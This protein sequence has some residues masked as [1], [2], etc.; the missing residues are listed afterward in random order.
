MGHRSDMKRNERE[1]G[2]GGYKVVALHLA[3]DCRRWWRSLNQGPWICHL[4]HHQ[5][6]T[7]I[8]LRSSAGSVS[9]KGHIC[10]QMPRT[11]FINFASQQQERGS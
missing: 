8:L 10:R 7:N 4:P 6:R 2:G 1:A 3:K 9:P 11:G 5:W